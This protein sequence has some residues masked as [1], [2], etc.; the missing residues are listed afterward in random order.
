[1]PRSFRFPDTPYMD[2][3]TKKPLNYYAV[4]YG[5]ITR[6]ALPEAWANKAKQAR[7]VRERKVQVIDKIQKRIRDRKEAFEKEMRTTAA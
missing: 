3:K 2:P 6:K 4:A 1:M 7:N 5:D